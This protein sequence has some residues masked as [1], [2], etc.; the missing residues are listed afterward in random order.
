MVADYGDDT[1]HSQYPD[2]VESP[3]D[4][5]FSAVFAQIRDFDRTVMS[6]V[7]SNAFL[8]LRQYTGRDIA[9]LHS[10][11]HFGSLDI[12]NQ[13]N[14]TSQVLKVSFNLTA[15]VI[16]TLTAK[17][18][19]IESVPQAVTNKG[20]VKGRRLAEDLNHLMKG[21]FH[22]HNVSNMINLAFRDA[23]IKRMGYIKVC[24][25]EK[26]GIKL[27]RLYFD[28]VVIDPADGYYNN[29]YKAIHRKAIPVE[30]VK[31]MFPNNLKDIEACEV[32]EIRL[33]NTRN[34]TPCIT[35][36]ESWCKNTYKPGGRHVI[37]IEVCDLV[38]EEWDK[39]YLPI[40]KIDYNQPVVGYMGN[41]VV[42]DLLPIQMEIDRV[43]VSM[44]AI[45]K[46]MSVPT[47]LV[48]TNAQMS[49]NH[50]TNKVGLIWEGDYK[51]GIAPILHNGA[52]MPPEIMEALQFL[53]QQGYARAG[54]TA[55]D[56]QGEQKT[57]TGNTSG[58]ALK[59][60]TDIKSERWQLLQHNFEKKH[61]ELAEI[62]L[63]ELQGTKLKISAIDRNIG[64][65]EVNTKVIPK[66][67]D[68]Y[69]IRM[70]P[71]SS[72]PD[73][74]PDL[75]D[76]VSQMLQLGVIQPSQVPDLFNMPDIDA[77]IALQTAPR[78][79][80]DKRLEDMIDSG[81]YTNPEPYHDLQYA[82][83]AAMQQYNFAQLNNESDKVLGLLRRY[84]KDVQEL[85]KQIPPPPA[86]IAPIKK[87]PQ[88]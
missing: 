30:V 68:S 50:R 47:W 54:L 63:K 60:M 84:I 4:N 58:E 6:S 78:K 2:W 22:K 26:D 49:K 1:L 57:G 82:A 41:S 62:I 46:T 29:P 33:Y 31:Q 71:V 45:L 35:V 3:K 43:L 28:E 8:G 7:S 27:D 5:V 11:T 36:A 18:A 21:L 86:P 65:R 12:N 69:V 87:G 77:S 72:L 76:S 53:I 66:I 79:L 13:M 40:M 15:L 44:Q 16:D 74:I 51:N 52:A 81:K 85:I 61:V 24:K 39:D 42:D 25:D 88:Q 70:Y 80:I 23:M 32:K 59:T 55:M 14:L 9:S 10:S 34:Y 19:S 83:V 64:L 20:N 56:T 73:S 75:I 38:D 17:L 48:D 67:A 37:S